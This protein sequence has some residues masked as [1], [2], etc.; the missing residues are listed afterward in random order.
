LQDNIRMNSL[1][2]QYDCARPDP[3]LLG[4]AYL[5]LVVGSA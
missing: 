5:P 4:G 3:D 1:F 2:G